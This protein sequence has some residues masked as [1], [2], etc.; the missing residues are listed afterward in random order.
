[1]RWVSAGLGKQ[2][3]VSDI[4]A[5]FWTIAPLM[6]VARATLAEKRNIAIFARCMTKMDKSKEVKTLETEL[7]AHDLDFDN[8]DS[9]IA[10]RAVA[11][12]SQQ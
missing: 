6:Q 3:N 11:A 1:M 2:W 9:R 10:K 5:S 7:K 12:L 8:M 4:L